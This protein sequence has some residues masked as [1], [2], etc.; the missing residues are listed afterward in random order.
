MKF[1]TSITRILLLKFSVNHSIA[2]KKEYIT[3][4]FRLFLATMMRFTAIIFLFLVFR[5]CVSAQSRQERNELMKLVE[6]RQ[7]LFDSY[8]ASLKKKSG[9]FGQKT[10]NDLRATHDRLKNIV[11]VDNKIMARLRQLLD[12][13][14]FEKQTMSYDV[15]QYAEQL[16]NYERNQDTLV[17]QLAQLEKEKAKL[18]NSISRRSSWIYFLLGIFC[19]WIF[20][21][22]HRKYFAGGA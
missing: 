4:Y 15:N 19:S 22:I 8:S 10:K 5:I 2:D 6:E 12:Y 16:K 13:S 1:R 18:T 20:Y 21:R 11:E 9:F 14:K 3:G 17:K 7:E